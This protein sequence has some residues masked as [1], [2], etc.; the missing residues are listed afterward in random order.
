MENFR[1]DKEKYMDRL[2][3]VYP[4]CSKQE[5]TQILL[6]RLSFWEMIIDDFENLE[7]NY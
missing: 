3:E 2:Q 1:L 4:Q 5:L 7:I 6:L